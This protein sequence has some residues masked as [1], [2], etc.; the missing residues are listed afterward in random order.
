MNRIHDLYRPASVRAHDYEEVEKRLGLHELAPQAERCHDC[1]IPFCHDFGCPL[2]NVIPEFNRAVARGDMRGAWEILSET[3]FFPEFTS[4]VCPALCEGSCTCGID[5]EP[6]MIRQTEKLITATAFAEGWVRPVLPPARNGKKVAVIGGGPS[7]LA[8][9]EALNRAGFTVTVYE[10]RRRPG[11]LLRYGIPDFKLAKAL[12]D[13]RLEIM[14]AAGIT[15]VGDT[16]V[17][18]DVSAEYLRRQHDALV[19]AIG[20]AAARDLPVPGRELKGI[21]FALEFLRGQN[22]ANSGELPAAPVS[23]AGKEVLV[24][25]GG[26]TGS[27]CVGTAIRQGA[28]A[29]T[30]IEIMPRP[31]AGR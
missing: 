10:A 6:V 7:G 25:G 29:V 28:K 12:I 17:G 24:I 4:R 30:Q 1:G 15:F 22:M 16:E 23:A 31:P 27:D 26:D 11:G 20:T 21:H 14:T 19:V 3:S 5:E 13:R 2:G 18:R 8:A 9:A